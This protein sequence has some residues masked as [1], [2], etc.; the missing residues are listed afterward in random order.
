MLTT[1]LGMEGLGY[2]C[3]DN[4]LIFSLNA[5][6]W[7]LQLPLVKFGSPAQQQAWLPGL[8]GGELL[9]GRAMTEAGAGSDAYAMRT[10]FER[11]G[12]SYVLNGTKLYITNAPVADVVL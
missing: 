5:Q 12:D 10:R 11:R 8:I 2:G 9:G 1:V 4:G 6:M 3:H 7:S